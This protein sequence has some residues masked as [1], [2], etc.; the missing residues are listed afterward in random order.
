M[1]ENDRPVKAMAE[2]TARSAPIA[3]AAR[4]SYRGAGA[5]RG[6]GPRPR[7]GAGDLPDGRAALQSRRTSA[8]AHA[9]RA[10][11]PAKR[12]QKTIVFVTRTTR[13]RRWTEFQGAIAVLKDGPSPVST[14]PH[15]LPQAGGALHHRVHWAGGHRTRWMRGGERRLPAG[16]IA[17]PVQ[18]GP[19]GRSHSASG[20][21]RSR[22][23]REVLPMPSC[24]RGR[25]GAGRARHADSSCGMPAHD[26]RGRTLARTRRSR[27]GHADPPALLR[28][29][30][31][32][33][34]F[35]PAVGPPALSPIAFSPLGIAGPLLWWLLWRLN[36][37]T[38]LAHETVE[39][40]F[41]D[42]RFSAQCLVQ[43]VWLRWFEGRAQV[44]GCTG[45]DRG[46]HPPSS[47]WRLE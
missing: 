35:A 33:I 26:L 19:R 37:A 11:T 17:L 21:S 25:H 1:D 32:L 2:L 34:G 20:P 47:I 7:L 43:L 42:A 36:R 46:W 24:C 39:M 16:G 27:A 3:F 8:P 4:R 13:K 23:S 18:G 29:N 15:D 45:D 28:P 38:P 6:G 12:S 5:A 30:G 41:W 31:S 40:V 9:H 10:A 14:S 44:H 22:S